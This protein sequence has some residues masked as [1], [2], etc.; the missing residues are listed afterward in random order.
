MSL[1]MGKFF[2]FLQ[3]P[4]AT[5][6]FSGFDPNSFVTPMAAPI[7]PLSSDPMGVGPMSTVPTPI[8]MVGIPGVTSIPHVVPQPI[9]LTLEKTPATA[10]EEMRKKM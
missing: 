5:M 9:A 8:P 1:L 4:I 3:I 10:L 6:I 7:A 2:E